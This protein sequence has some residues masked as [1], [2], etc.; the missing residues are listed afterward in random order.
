MGFCGTPTTIFDAI[1]EHLIEQDK[2]SSDET[3]IAL[4]VNRIVLILNTHSYKRRSSSTIPNGKN[5]STA[6]AMTT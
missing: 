5:I 3:K 4:L 2:T 6:M 1:A